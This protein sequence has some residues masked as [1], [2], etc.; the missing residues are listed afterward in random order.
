MVRAGWYKES[1]RHSLAAR[2]I[3]T[4]K[5]MAPKFLSGL[6]SKLTGLVRKDVLRQELGE[7]IPRDAERQKERIEEGI[8][9]AGG[10]R[11]TTGQAAR[12]R[13][14]A[15]IAVEEAAKKV[16]VGARDIEVA[17]DN[18]DKNRPAMALSMIAEAR[19]RGLSSENV[20][21]L[22]TAL[23]AYSIKL[24]QSGLPVP[25]DIKGMLDRNFKTRL[26]AV[27]TE[28]EREGESA[29]R[30]KLRQAGRAATVATVE[31]L[32]AAL[33]GGGLSTI[34]AQDQEFT[35]VAANIDKLE[36]TPMFDPVNP[37]AEGGRSGANAF[38]DDKGKFGDF[39]VPKTSD[40]FN[41]A[42]LRGDGNTNVALNNDAGNLA[43]NIT[44]VAL[45]ES[46][47]GE[48]R[49][50]VKT[51]AENVSEQVESLH[52]ERAKLAAV[53]LSAFDEG[54]KAFKS[55]DREGLI[56]AI[57]E[58]QSQEGKLKDRWDLVGQTHAQLKDA[59]NH[60][61]AFEKKKSGGFLGGVL[62]G[63]RGADRFVEQT[64]KLSNVRGDIMDASNRAFGRR[65]ML[66]FRLQR[67][68]SQVPPETWV[69][70]KITRF[71]DDAGNSLNGM[72]DKAAGW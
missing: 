41:F 58:L 3:S 63:G 53:D 54:D 18:L 9:V 19:Q 35:G 4:R 30:T 67:L 44:N 47:G 49:Q 14:E 64:E 10:P 7:P 72:F 17:L 1:F 70:R 39:E 71:S 66:E 69:P 56:S 60:A 25:K 11:T 12:K 13:I 65:K 37:H 40:S 15:G 42:P 2:G 16:V 57:T 48:S 24:A 50:E 43:G 8:V 6:K 28:F 38:V 23:G 52:K 20:S 32:P 59:T 21:Q 5:Y 68:D 62:A 34:S 22:K 46:F 29:L 33:K 26:S 51:P 45:G 61:S 31:A 55:G 36:K 27:E